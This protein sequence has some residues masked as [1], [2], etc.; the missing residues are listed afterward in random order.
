MTKGPSLEDDGI[1]FPEYKEGIPGVQ[2]E[3]IGSYSTTFNPGYDP[4]V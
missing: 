1:R 2:P 3:R 4:S